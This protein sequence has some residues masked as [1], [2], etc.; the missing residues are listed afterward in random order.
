MD[1]TP[2]VVKFCLGSQKNQFLENVSTQVF[3][4]LEGGR[5]RAG[6]VAVGAGWDAGNGPKSGGYLGR[7]ITNQK[8]RNTESLGL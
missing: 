4:F 7:W 2:E 8:K 3:P 6:V 5:G 1:V